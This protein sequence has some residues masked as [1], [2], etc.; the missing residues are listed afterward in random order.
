M[1]FEI[2]WFTRN[3]TWY[4]R[5]LAKFAQDVLWEKGKHIQYSK[6]QKAIKVNG[7][8]G[9]MLMYSHLQMF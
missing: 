1:N 8:Q 7:P 4:S 5:V 9:T 3:S 2:S 6:H